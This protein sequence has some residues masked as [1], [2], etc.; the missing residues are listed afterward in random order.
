MAADFEFISDATLKL[1]SFPTSFIICISIIKKMVDFDF[2]WEM[3]EFLRV[4]I[5]VFLLNIKDDGVEIEC[6]F[7][8]EFY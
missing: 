4:V 6:E 8:M 7:E 5:C 2:C 1:T 3:F